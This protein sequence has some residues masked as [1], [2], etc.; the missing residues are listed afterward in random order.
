VS[1]FIAASLALVAFLW[2]V[3]AQQL[4]WKVIACTVEGPQEFRGLV[5]T[6]YFSEKGLAHFNGTQYPATVTGAEIQ[7]CIPDPNNQSKA[8][9]CYNISR[10]SARFSFTLATTVL[11]GSCVPGDKP[12]F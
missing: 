3:T 12:K 2:P 1:K 10:L 9:G 7:F 5:V 4:E 11:M 6:I 8:P